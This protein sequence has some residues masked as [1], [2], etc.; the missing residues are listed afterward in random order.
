MEHT[1][2]VRIE[3]KIVPY[4]LKD[5]K[6]NLIPNNTYASLLPGDVKENEVIKGVTTGNREIAFIGCKY[7][8]CSLGYKALVI[9]NCNIIVDLPSARWRLRMTEMV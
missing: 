8:N 7:N 1:G 5:K 4:H 3:R 2:H 9:S 6:V